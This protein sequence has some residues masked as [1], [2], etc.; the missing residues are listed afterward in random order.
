MEIGLLI[1]AFMVLG[2]QWLVLR[3]VRRIVP[4]GTRP[5]LGKASRVLNEAVRRVL[6]DQKDNSEVSTSFPYRERMTP[7]EFS[8]YAEKRNLELH[9]EA[10]H[11]SE[12]N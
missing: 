5:P 10:G 4:L 12:I 2:M 6:N 1:V 3:E 9:K 11:A 7:D 8:R